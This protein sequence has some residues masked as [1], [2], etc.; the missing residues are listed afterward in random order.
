VATAGTDY[1]VPPSGTAILKANS[2]VGLA[3]AIPGTDYAGITNAQTFTSSQRGSVTTDNDLS[4]NLNTTNNFKCTTAGSGTLTFTNF[5]A[6]QSGYVLLNN[7]LGF[8]ISAA[9][10]VKVT[11]TFLP[12]ISTAGTYLISYFCDGT[13]VYCTASGA[14]D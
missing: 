14:L 11:T 7:N 9:A 10:T 4:L 2:G 13:N 6:G 1:L 3:A 8:A 5:V 12:V